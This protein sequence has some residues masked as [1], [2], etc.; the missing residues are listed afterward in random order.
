MFEGINCM[1]RSPEVTDGEL[2]AVHARE[3]AT[4]IEPYRSGVE[5]MHHAARRSLS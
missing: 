3:A 4:D 1:S 2:K 5:Q